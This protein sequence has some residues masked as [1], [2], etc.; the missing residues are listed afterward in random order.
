MNERSQLLDQRIL[1]TLRAMNGALLAEATLQDGV[2]L[3]LTP[4]LLSAELQERLR[5]LESQGFLIGLPD[6]YGAPK[7]K[8][9]DA[10][11]IFCVESGF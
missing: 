5:F 7:W 2:G 6:V 1:R 11:R 9:T 10:G 4:R 3:N 8:I